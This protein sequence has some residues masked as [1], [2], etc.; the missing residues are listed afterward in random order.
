MFDE[1][2]GIKKLMEDLKS[3]AQDY[4]TRHKGVMTG[5]HIC[6]L[7]PEH[8]DKSPSMSYFLAGDVY[9]CFSCGRSADIFTLAH[10]FE[11][12][13]LA[14]RS[15]IEE[16][17]FYLAEKYGMEY[18]HLQKE[19]TPEEMER[20]S[21]F[22]VMKMF[23]DYVVVNKNDEFLDRRGIKQEIAK[24][25]G[26]GSVR[27]FEHCKSELLKNGATEQ[28]LD[29]IGISRF[30]IN[31]NKLIMIIKDEYDRP[32]SFTSREMKYDKKGLLNTYPNLKDLVENKKNIEHELFKSNMIELSGLPWETIDK[33][34]STPKYINGGATG[35]FNKSKIFYGWSDIKK[36]FRGT[37]TLVIV[38][39]YIDFVTAYQ[40]GIRNV[41]AIGSAS[42]TDDHIGF[43][44]RNNE[45]KSVAIA[46]DSDKVGIERTKSI[47]ERLVKRSTIKIY[48]FAEYK[49]SSK[50]ID[51]AINEDK[52]IINTDMLF[53]FIDMFEFELKVLKEEAGGNF[54]QDVVFDKF[55]GL[56]AKE[57]EPKRRNQMARA[58]S[59]IATDY[60]FSTIIDQVKY[61]T[62]GKEDLYN[63]TIIN[64]VESVMGHVKKNPENAIKSLNTLTSELE[65][66][67]KDFGKK[68]S[69]VFERSMDRFE[70]V[71]KKK[72][73]KELF[74]I[75]FGIPWLDDLN[76]QPGNSFVISSLA[77]TGKSTIFQHLVKT[78]L[79]K[80]L[81][82]KVHVFFATTDDPGSKVYSNLIASISGLSREYCTNPLY[83]KTWGYNTNPESEISILYKQKYDAAEDAVKFLLKS[84]KL[85]L[86]DVSDKIDNWSNLADTMREISESPELEDVYKILILDS[87]N[88]VSVDG[89]S[90]ENQR[91][92]FLSEHIKKQ[93]E[94]YGF[95]SFVNFEL[96]KL[97]NNSKLSQYSLSGSKRMYYDCDVL[98]FVYNPMRN[99]SNDTML[100]WEK[101]EPGVP[102]TKE[103]ILV[104]IQEK[105]KAGNNFMNSRPYF[106]ELDSSNNKLNPI[107]PG[108]PKHNTYEQIWDE[109]FSGPN[110]K[111]TDGFKKKY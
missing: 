42:F 92:A 76:I 16:N 107:V 28:M 81:G 59:K 40:A 98:G 51:E 43:I 96:N 66:I 56:I 27:S 52:T 6:C 110:A 32:V 99:L 17:V 25:L 49:N 95:L 79:S 7:F 26:I 109:E 100:Y 78:V 93:S 70:T 111:Y 90:D 82:N 106:Y 22:R 72:E 64:R 84:K 85:T 68:F 94:T 91:A 89:I 10:L 8:E 38:E 30:K 69:N 80:R 29:E 50:D 74:T 33:Y 18:T 57:V 23:S 58:L 13:P 108:T 12:K 31:E 63:K 102:M 46:L 5:T 97:A 34:L 55:V 88:K 37:S 61:L 48:K 15:F 105:S 4:Y 20:Q 45:I 77:N 9:H 60:D 11:G 54:D 24:K 41:I 87:A 75:K 44:E 47:L 62:D 73:I 86:L 2:L 103:P 14:G 19:L 104:T 53:N 65:N 21:Y 3:K 83:H 36:Q 35:I 1:N 39:G 71:A 67:D 101:S